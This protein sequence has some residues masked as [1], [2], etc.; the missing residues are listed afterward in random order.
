MRSSIVFGGLSILTIVVLGAA[1]GCPTGGE[2]QECDPLASENQCPPGDGFAQFCSAPDGNVCVNVCEG[3]NIL[4]GD[5]CEFDSN[6]DSPLTCDNDRVAVSSCKC[7]L[8]CPSVGADPG[9][10]QAGGACS[11]TTDCA[12]DLTCDNE[13]VGVSSCTCMVETG[14]MGDLGDSCQSTADCDPNAS[15]LGAYCCTEN[16]ATCGDNLGECVE[17][18]STFSSGGQVGVSEGELCEN[19]NECGPGLFCCLVPDA[20]GNCNFALDQSCTC[21]NLDGGECDE[22]VG[23]NTA[24]PGAPPNLSTSCMPGEEQ[25]SCTCMT[26]NGET[27]TAFVSP[28]GC[29]F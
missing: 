12:Q 14:G 26:Q 17:D 15:S 25:F 21:R 22:C 7:V 6:C 4:G 2:G 1:S 19:N 20:A 5:S 13:M 27:L 16:A 3:A 23:V 18:C 28:G 11:Q 8:A 24:A 9:S 10:V 29:F